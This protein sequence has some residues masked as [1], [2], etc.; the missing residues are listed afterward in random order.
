[1]SQLRVL[2]GYKN[3]GAY[4]GVSHIGLGVSAMNTAKTLHHLGVHCEVLPMKDQL[5]LRKHL[6]LEASKGRRYSHVVI[7]AP[8]ITTAAFSQVSSLFPY[9]QFAMNCHSNVGFLQADSKGIQLLREDLSLQA[10]VHNFHVAANSKRL[11]EFV[12]NAYGDP[13]LYLPNLYYLDHMRDPCHPLWSQHGGTLR[14][15]VFGATRSLKNILTSVGA[16]L[17]IARDLKAHTQIWLSTGRV[18]GPEVATIM[19]AVNALVKD[20]PNV[21]LKSANWSSW[22]QFRKLVGSMHLL[23]Q[24][25]YTESFNMVTADGAAEGVPSVVSEAIVW[26]PNEWKAD[27]DDVDDVARHGIALLHD[28]RAA[29][30]GLRALKAHNLEGIDYWRRWLKS[31]GCYDPRSAVVSFD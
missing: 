26:A 5:D 15:G 6:N 10:G 7:S 17:V 16:A 12:E 18:D 25:S 2:L 29:R 8:W 30:N 11:Q 20:V 23:L 21:E 28:V 24:P 4:Q 27:V 19:R 13:C 9:T 22:P 14:L 31:P 1:M 3:F